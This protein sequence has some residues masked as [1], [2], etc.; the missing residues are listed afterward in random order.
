MEKLLAILIFVF[1][2]QSCKD[3]TVEKKEIL[4]QKIEEKIVE[5]PKTESEKIIEIIRNGDLKG[6]QNLLKKGIDVNAR[7]EGFFRGG[8]QENVND[9]SN[10][11]WTMLMVASFYNK[12]KIAEFLLQ[13]KAEI[14][15][16]N[17]AGHTALFLSCA[18][19]SE[20]MAKFL[21]EHNAD[22]KIDSKDS[23]GTS[24]LQWA[25]AYEWNDVAEDLLKQDVDVNS[26]STET[27]RDVLMDA[28]YSESISKNVISKIIEKGANINY[29]NRKDGENALMWVCKRDF[30]DIAKKIVDKGGNVNS[31]SQNGTTPLSSA[32]G[33][34]SCSTELMD[35][36]IKNGAKINPSNKYGRTPLIEAVSSNCI[37]KVKFL[38]E[39]GASVNQ[40]SEG[41]GGVSPLSE[42]VW[43]TNFEITK[44][45]VENG[46]DVNIQKE[47]GDTAL[48]VAVWNEKNLNAVNLLIQRGADVNKMNDDKQTPLL[49]AIQYNHYD[50]A[51]LLIKNGAGTDVTDFYG[52][53]IQSTLKETV[54]RTGNKKWLGLKL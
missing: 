32:S 45:F 27:G 21:L 4:V 1:A 42:A 39:K 7:F 48:L 29:V 17:K 20:E 41:F 24:A 44:Y 2:L 34:N 9:I 23:S 6:V 15:L 18:N 22:A 52:H 5:L 11:Q 19:R 35:F 53:T 54:E 25:L 49:K 16:Q 3:K 26:R 33:K 37:E 28:L 13:N 31:T 40:K 10:K 47:N 14:N 30:S 50:I 43:E 38:V 12:V 46:A 36:L 8:R 51:V